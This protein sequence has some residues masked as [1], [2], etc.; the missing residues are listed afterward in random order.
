[1]LKYITRR[2]LISV[3]VLFGITVIDFLIMKLAPGSPL[4]LMKNPMI[5]ASTLAIRAK[6]LGLTDP[7]YIQ[8][9]NWFKDILHGN[10]GYSMISYEPVSGLIASHIWP[11]ILLMTVSLLLGLLIAVPIGILSATK[12]Y[13]ILDY[14]TVTGSFIG[15][16]IPNF[17]LSLGLIYLFTIKLGVLPSGGMTTL[18][19]SGGALDI[20]THMIM[21]TIVLATSV[22]GRNIRY[23]RSSMLEVLGQDYLR[24][25]RAK[26]L[27]EF[28][29][30]NKHAIRNALVPIISVV[31]MEIP[32]IFGGAVII[33]QIFSWPG[34]GLLTMS[35]IMTRD[36]PTV[37]GLNLMVA[38]IVIL[39]NLF[40]DVV[41]ALVD[42]TIKYS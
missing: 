27:R 30:I 18:G 3:P 22:A 15:I 28:L 13:S 41:Y 23:V 5:P 9:A 34:I 12:Q 21:P 20:L 33:E 4:D 37:M 10:L 31:G 1:M 16:S 25:A 14:L 7:V 19:N 24:T 39:A 17:F 35:S 42:P 36:Y 6:A 40:T 8:F 2:L 29:V 32:M 26:G 11:T 38:V